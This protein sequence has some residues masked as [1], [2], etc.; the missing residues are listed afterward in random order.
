M[1]R[2]TPVP[3]FPQGHPAIARLNTRLAQELRKVGR[4]ADA[5]HTE[6]KVVSYARSF[7]TRSNETFFEQDVNFLAKVL[8]QQESKQGSSLKKA[9]SKLDSTGPRPSLTWVDQ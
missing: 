6:Q 7:S 3:Q 9:R 2:C 5:K 4:V 8:E 1:N